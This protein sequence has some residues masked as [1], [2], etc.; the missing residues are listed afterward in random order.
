MDVIGT[1]VSL[2]Q[3]LGSLGPRILQ[4]LRDVVVQIV[5]YIL[6]SLGKRKV[7][8]RIRQAR[9]KSELTEMVTESAINWVTEVKRQDRTGNHRKQPVQERCSPIRGSNI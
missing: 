8:D 7:Y 5:D 2:S 6:S 3:P 9:E 4:K 1:K